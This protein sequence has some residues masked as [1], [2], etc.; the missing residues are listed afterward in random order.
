MCLSRCSQLRSGPNCCLE[1]DCTRF[2]L[3]FH[4]GKPWVV[5]GGGGGGGERHNA[6]GERFKSACVCEVLVCVNCSW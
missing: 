4:L 2:I 5:G 6:V 1:E 3:I